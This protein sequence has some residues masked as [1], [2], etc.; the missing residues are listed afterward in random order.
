[1]TVAGDAGGPVGSAAVTVELWAAG[2]GA[3]TEAGG[4]SEE[5]V[6]ELDIVWVC[7]CVYGGGGD[8]RERMSAR[9][10]V[11]ERSGGRLMERDGEW[12]GE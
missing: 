8:E 7:V 4:D 9:K 6:P 10:C 2:S 12:L 11:Y 5:G 1:M 3:M